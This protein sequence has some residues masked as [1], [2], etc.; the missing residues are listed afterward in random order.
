MHIPYR[1][2]PMSTTVNLTKEA[3]DITLNNIVEAVSRHAT[4]HGESPVA[5]VLSRGQY[6]RVYR[7]YCNETRAKG[8]VPAAK[9]TEIQAVPVSVV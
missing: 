4:T 8:R 6:A 7:G 5:V 1:R 3:A 9:L 2:P